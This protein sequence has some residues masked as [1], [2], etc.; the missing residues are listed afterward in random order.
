MESIR[1]AKSAL[2]VAILL[3]GV[4]AGTVLYYNNALNSKNSEIALLESQV[5]NQ[6]DEIAN[7]NSQVSNLT[8]QLTQIINLTAP[9]A[10]ITAITESTDNGPV[11]TMFI[12]T[13]YVNVTNTGL[14]DINGSTLTVQNI[15]TDGV[16]LK[17]ASSRAV[18]LLHPYENRRVICEIDVDLRQVDEASS[19]KYIV[20]LNL[21]GT[22]LDTK[23]Y[24]FSSG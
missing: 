22:T 6:N 23:Y 9:R 8:S 18:P 20:T 15:A 24:S 10:V 12:M 5:S 16:G 11:G 19:L 13:F 1:K 7:L 4:N 3:I 2:I 14:K 21:N 17:Y